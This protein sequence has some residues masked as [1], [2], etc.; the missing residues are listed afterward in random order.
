MGKVLP[1]LALRAFTETGRTGSIK[2]AAEVMGVTSGAVSQQ[3]RLLEERTGVNLFRRTRYG[4]ELTEEGANVYP[5][6]LRAFA[7][8]EASLTTLEA[9]S[10]RQTLTVSTLPSFAASWLV[11]RLGRFMAQNPEIEVRVEASSG[12]T[13]LHGGRVDIALRHGL[14]NYPDYEVQPLMAPA[15]VPVISAALLASGPVIE[16][17]SDCLAYPL[18][19]DSDRADWR[20]W[21][22]ACGVEATPEAERGTAFDEDFLLLKAAEA[23]QGIALIRDIYAKPEIAAGRLTLAIDRPWPTQFAYYILTLPENA[24]KPA[25]KLFIEWLHQEA[26]VN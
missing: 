11:P 12:L 23:G 18:L 7:Q 24:Q 22:T 4:V 13:N 25:L 10:Q 3:I 8:I 15:L 6:L 9:S 1:L 21:L 16:Q 2:S 5:A 14:G 20:L 17:P 26:S 19:Q